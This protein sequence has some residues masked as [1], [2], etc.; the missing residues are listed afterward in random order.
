MFLNPIALFVVTSHITKATL[1]ILKRIGIVH[2]LLFR[3]DL[4]LF[5][6]MV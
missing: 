2:I 1:P 4:D 5:L 3:V 6:A